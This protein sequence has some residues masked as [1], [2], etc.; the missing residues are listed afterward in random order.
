M[1]QNDERKKNQ[2]KSMHM[3]IHNYYCYEFNIKRDV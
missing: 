1:C 3:I 2:E